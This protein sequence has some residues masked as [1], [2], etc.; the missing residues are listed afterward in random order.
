MTATM[1]LKEIQALPVR[2]KTKLLKRLER[3]REVAE[4]LDDVRLFDEAKRAVAGQKPVSF[5]SVVKNS[6][7]QLLQ[8]IASINQKMRTTLTAKEMNAARLE[9]RK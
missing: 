8:F 4:E 7:E 9:G 6:E 3:E 1:I 2:E 5:R